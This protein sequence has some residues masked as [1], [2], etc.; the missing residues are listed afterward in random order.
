MNKKILGAD[1][2][3]DA[4]RDVAEAL[5]SAVL[6]ADFMPAPEELGRDI[7]QHVSL[8]IDKDI[9]EW[10]RRPGGGYQTRINAVLRAYMVANQKVHSRSARKRWAPDGSSEADKRMP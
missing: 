7:K 8:R 4:P 5:A 3:E 1:R 10:F 2:Y 9:L 6:V